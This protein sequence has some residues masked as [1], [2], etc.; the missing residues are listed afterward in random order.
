MQVHFEHNQWHKAIAMFSRTDSTISE[1]LETRIMHYLVGIAGEIGEAHQALTNIIVLRAQGET[2]PVEVYDDMLLE[3]GDLI[4]YN[5]LLMNTTL[6]MSEEM[7]DEAT[8]GLDYG[9]D[10][11]AIELDENTVSNYRALV[12]TDGFDALG[13]VS[14]LLEAHLMKRVTERLDDF[15]KVFF[16]K[17]EFTVEELEA[18]N[19]F[20][21]DTHRLLQTCA[22]FLGTD[23]NKLANMVI[24]KLK[25]RYPEQ[26]TPQLSEERNPEKEMADVQEAK[27]K[28][29]EDESTEV[30]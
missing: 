27:E 10:N 21:Y 25:S 17:T 5:S 13:Y 1:P 20:S 14:L 28:G 7:S 12:G 16:Y 11:L 26:F 22:F 18:L 8:V 24:T 3:I 6:L 9:I 2:E 23:V 4:W 30:K 19:Q 15:K 29:N